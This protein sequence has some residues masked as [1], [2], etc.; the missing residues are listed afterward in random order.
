MGGLRVE[1]GSDVLRDAGRVMA[2][3]KKKKKNSNGDGGGVQ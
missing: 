2:S 3:K 1:V